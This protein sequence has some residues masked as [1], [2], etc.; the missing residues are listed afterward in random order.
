MKSFV[1]TLAG[2]VFGVLSG[3]DRLMFRGH[4]RELA[5][6]GGMN[7]Y[8][9][10][11]GVKLVE[12]GKQNVCRTEAQ[13]RHHAKIT[14]NASPRHEYCCSVFSESLCLWFPLAMTSKE[15]S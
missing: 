15:T 4:L 3:F 8:C 7:Y 10:C 6:A 12:F 1:Q 5:Y 2:L 11:N 14:L 13:R 9:N